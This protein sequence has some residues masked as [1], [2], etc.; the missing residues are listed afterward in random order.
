ME[1]PSAQWNEMDFLNVGRCQGFMVGLRDGIV[2]SLALLRHDNPSLASL[3]GSEEDFGICFPDGV[4]IGQ[5]IRVTLKYIRQH[6]EQAHLHSAQ[7]VFMAELDAFP[8]SK[9]A[10][11][12]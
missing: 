3:K 11:K 1:K 12:Q 10:Q 4:E 9:P 8:C 6:P 2:I 5:M 7:L